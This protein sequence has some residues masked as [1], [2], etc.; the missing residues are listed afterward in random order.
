[1][2]MAHMLHTVLAQTGAAGYYN[3]VS[4]LVMKGV[5]FENNTANA[6]AGALEMNQC[7]GDVQTC[8]FAKNK[9]C[10]RQDFLIIQLR[11][12]NVLNACRVTNGAG[13]GPVA[14]CR[15]SAIPPQKDCPAVSIAAPRVSCSSYDP[16]TADGLG[17]VHVPDDAL[18]LRYGQGEKGG[19]L[20]MDSC[21]GNV[22]NCTFD[23]NTASQQGAPAFL[24]PE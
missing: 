5:L 12:C 17:I 23:A 4:K 15:L 6:G 24:P 9:V 3:R 10:L 2:L 20:F 11:N 16:F 8:V 14:S 13:F 18:A 19:G 1:M 7:S 22:I 21:Q